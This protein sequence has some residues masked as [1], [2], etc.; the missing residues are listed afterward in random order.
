M[1]VSYGP[2]P[3]HQGELRTGGGPLTILIHGG[4]FRDE[5]QRDTMESLA[6]EFTRRGHDTWNIGYRR[7]GS[8]GGWPAAGHDVA[9]AL[10]YARSP[11]G[12][13]RSEI[14]VISHSAGGYLTMWAA[15]RID[16]NLRHVALAPMSDLEASVDRSD[17][18]APQAAQMIAMN[19]PPRVAPGTVDTLVVH[20]ERDDVVDITDTRTLMEF[21]PDNLI[22]GDFGHFELLNP[23]HDLWN[24]V[25][26]RL[27]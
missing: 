21:A 18:C 1:T 8:G 7:L 12:L 11:W 16:P 14:T 15:Q 23:D 3:D 26:V 24:E 25:R 19:A 6:V 20:G 27:T 22:T 2:H 10:A 5:F 9:M 17:V 13:D 4:V